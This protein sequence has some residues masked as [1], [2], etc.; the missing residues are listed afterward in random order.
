MRKKR[1]HIAF[2]EANVMDKFSNQIVKGAMA[3]AEKYDVDMTIFPVKYV[4]HDIRQDVDALFEYQYNSLLSLAASGKFDYIV[5]SIGSIGYACSLDKKIQILQ[6][7]DN[8][9]ILCVCDEVPGYDFVRYENA[10]G[11]GEAV[12]YLVK[13]GRKHICMMGGDSNNVDCEERYMAYRAALERN[14]IPFEERF[15]KRCDLAGRDD[16]E[17]DV[18][19]NE[20]PEVDAIICVTDMIAATVCETVKKRNKRIGEDIAVVGFDDLPFAAQCNPPLASVRADAQQLGFYSIQCVVNILNGRDDGERFL[21]SSFVQ[22]ASCMYDGDRL[23]DKLDMFE[24]TYEAIATN[25]LGYIYEDQELSDN[26]VMVRSFCVYAVSMIMERIVEGRCQEADVSYICHML[27]SFFDGNQYHHDILLRIMDVFEYAVE[28]VGKECVSDH[29][30]KAMDRIRKVV[31]A[32]FMTGL[33]SITS[34]ESN[35]TFDYAHNTNLVIRES[36]MFGEDLKN[37]YSNV[38]SKLYALDLK[39]SYLYLLREPM[40]YH[41]GEIFPQDVQWQFKAY[42]DGVHAFAIPPEEQNVPPDYM[43]HNPFISDDERHT[44][45]VVDLYSREYQYGVLISEIQSE[46]FLMTWE[47]VVYQMSAAVKMVGLL[48]AQNRILEE[49]H[50]KNLSLEEESKL[51]ELTG[52]YNRRGFY[53]AANKL[54]AMEQNV[55]K[56]WIIC[57]ADMD[58]LKEVNDT[59]GHIE[60][61]YS[62]KSLADCLHMVLGDSA[63]VGRVGGDEFIAVIDK[64]KVVSCEEVLRRKEQWIKGLN[65]TS[66]KPY[67]IDMS[68]GL[69]ECRCQNS[70][71][72]KDAIDKA[73]DILYA[74]KVKRKMNR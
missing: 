20:N 71:D 37:G 25:I 54:I 31:Y 70:Y 48:N 51:D 59:Y 13:S 26:Y 43:F 21:R 33:I 58:K 24:G 30:K 45:I 74:I 49:L 10:V 73:D 19:L 46:D 69:Y 1:F 63:V 36:L 68:M 64:G 12:D 2:V 50:T 5:I 42:Q 22:R 34:R 27:E 44:F 67:R 53:D 55:G 60:G 72:L 9:P 65:D 56:E 47:F 32:K 38:L 6:M 40:I 35:R 29:K 14:Q 66:M 41:N 39:K 4:N 23:V 52:L 57:Y 17:T 15:V 11:I 62:L 3:A 7:F 61:D 28:W 16:G 8:A 18:L